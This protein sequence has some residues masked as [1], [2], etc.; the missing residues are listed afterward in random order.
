MARRSVIALLLIS[1]P[2]TLCNDEDIISQNPKCKADFEALRDIC[3]MTNEQMNNNLAALDCVQNLP[4][5][6][7]SG[8]VSDQCQHHLW[9]YKLEIT[10]QDKFLS[11][12][13]EVCKD[14]KEDEEL[15]EKCHSASGGEK[16]E[17]GHFLTC[18][19]NNKHG[20]H[21]MACA[22]FL[23]R[24]ETLIFSDFR[25]LS[26]LVDKCNSSVT[27]LQCGRV[28]V[29][30]SDT[31][32]QGQT[33]AC[34]SKKFEDVDDECKH[35]ILRIAEF[36]AEDY[37]LDRALYMACRDDREALCP[38]VQH[39][40]GR[41]YE[42]LLRH[43][44]EKEMSDDCRQQLTRRQKLA[45]RDYKVDRQMT[46]ACKVEIKENKCKK[47]VS[48]DRDIKM[49]QILLCLEGAVREGKTVSGSC[50]GHVKDQRRQIMED[51]QVSPELVSDCH[52]D[53][54]HG[55][56]GMGRDGKTIHCLMKIAMEKPQGKEL[57]SACEKSLNDLVAETQLQNDW[58]ADPVLED[59]CEEVVLQACDPK[60]G[61]DAVMS[62]L[63]E[64]LS[65]QGGV[66]NEDCRSVLL[67]LHYFLSREVLLDENL[68]RK[69]KADASRMCGAEEGWHTQDKDPRHKL[70]FP[71]LVRN[72]YND[73]DD[74]DDY[75]KDGISNK[76]DKGDKDSKEE[77]GES[78]INLSS[79]C[80]DE[81][82]R[83][84]QQRAVSVHLHPEIEDACRDILHQA[85][86]T[87]VGP[88]EE[89]QC[90][91]DNMDTLP[92]ECKTAVVKYTK[93]EARNPYLNPILVQACGNVIHRQCGAEA[94]QRD[95]SGVMSCLVRYRMEHEPGSAGAMNYKCR[96]VVEHWQLLTLQDW[97]FSFK[98]KEAC[99][100]DIRGH[101][102]TSNPRSKMDIV[103]CLSQL[104]MNDTVLEDKHRVSK[105]CRH[106][107][108]LELLQKHSSIDMDPTLKEVCSED[109]Q[110]FC[111]DE[112]SSDGG[113][114]CLK[115]QKHKNLT[116]DC[117]KLLFKEEAEEAIDNSVDFAVLR[118]CKREIQEHCNEADE[119]SILVCL[120]DFKDQPNFD[121]K[122]RMIVNK[123]IVQHM[124]DY[125]LNPLLQKACH[126]DIP[127]FCHDVLLKKTNDDFKE[128]EVIECLKEK[129]S[130]KNNYLTDS[131]KNQVV[132]I[133]RETAGDLETGKLEADPVLAAKC[134]MSISH[135]SHGDG[136]TVITD[137]QIKECLKHMF[138]SKSLEDGKD[139]EKQVALMIEVTSVDVH[140]DP[141]L[142]KACAIDL[143]KFCRDVPRGDGRQF[144]CLVAISR[145]GRFSLEQTCRAKVLQRV[146]MYEMAVEV[147]P[148]ESVQ[149]L[150]YQVANS[151]QRSNIL[152][153][154][155]CFI[156]AIF[157]I[158]LFFG[159]VT[160]KL[161][162]EIKN[163]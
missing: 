119:S 145:E 49:A 75:P 136:S 162:S 42:C 70:V 150:F 3:G 153:M 58:E 147:A 24:I 85:C 116:P 94:K 132:N 54:S 96:T 66:M 72:L 67:Q 32:S 152:L 109:L 148:L 101:C 48:E 91:Q 27:R 64:Q 22:Q 140:I 26:E 114:E 123:R 112:E 111:S 57:S 129:F 4:A 38:D 134:P 81:V 21:N 115:D 158:G 7:T 55:C 41:V 61:N 76:I 15:L 43:K 28:N 45:A 95:G 5:G 36:Q 14:D 113:V 16:Q 83:V 19:V 69:C 155:G 97:R 156:A 141:L 46:K 44:M 13:Q 107:L 90:L 53:I 149:D 6:D 137:V 65:K 20:V 1:A 143:V 104:V 51:F 33:I 86:I 157:L 99:K 124:K 142:H 35:E 103:G 10:K 161:R 138:K 130:Q 59:A 117:R 92:P 37:Q 29:E 12:A 82:E 25:L 110:K 127:K 40:E 102:M 89:I 139:C 78:P 93:L 62:C 2:L 74:D 87:N 146:E 50:M 128:G 131:C 120:K 105:R 133:L 88:G 108:K 56:N 68:Y 118:G 151:K 17:P 121:Q 60:A 106:E 125:R 31:H 126:L 73:E 160:K 18:L 63:M 163:R 159:R 144:G 47:G 84:L 30:E 154:V 77:E 71:C 122:C 79:D 52:E 11:H 9:E 23:S 100:G 135:C 39:G 80:A 34:L 98:F 8:K